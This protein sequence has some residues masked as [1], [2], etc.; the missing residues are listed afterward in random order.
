MAG[1]MQRWTDSSEQRVT[2]WY[3]VAI[4]P[5]AR[6]ARHHD[7]HRDPRE[8]NRSA[9]CSKR[10]RVQQSVRGA[11]IRAG[12][13]RN[14]RQD[15]PGVR[16]LGKRIAIGLEDELWLVL[17]LMIAGRLHWKPPGARL[18]GKQ[19]LAAFDFP[20]GTLLLTEAGSKRRASLHVLRGS[21]A[22]RE[23]DPGGIEV[24]SAIARAVRTS[25][26]QREPHA[27]AGADRPALFSGIGNAYSD[28]ILHRGA[29]VAAGTDAEAL[30]RE[31]AR[32]LRGVA[33]RPRGM[34]RAAARRDAATASRRH[35]TAFRPG[36][37]VHGRFGKPCPVCGAPV[38]RIRYAD[39][40]TNYCPGCQ[41]G[42]RI[43]ADRSLSRLLKDDWPTAP[44]RAVEEGGLLPAWLS[45]MSAMFR[46]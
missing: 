15:G 24:L 39:N 16:R 40:E 1:G 36:M 14:R 3:E 12:D 34:D 42:G 30:G 26:A 32:L 27:Q 29:A 4:F 11:D 43:L 45:R 46:R 6:I 44:G 31:V 35:V 8:A 10:A 38:Q 41:T 5:Y 23:H 2:G 33:A 25:A 37:A 28:E 21:R 18:A 20:D 7:L 19:H 13:P 22:L 9:N 17:H